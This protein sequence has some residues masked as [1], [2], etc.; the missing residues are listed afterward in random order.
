MT[1]SFPTGT[2]LREGTKSLAYDGQNALKVP[3]NDKA[4]NVAQPQCQKMAAQLLYTVQ[5]LTASR[6]ARVELLRSDR[7]SLCSVTDAMA[8][9]SPT[10]RRAPSTSTTWTATAGSCG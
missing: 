10:G 8:G 7:S 9:G 6:L 3:L 1:S 5:D 2:E 4:D